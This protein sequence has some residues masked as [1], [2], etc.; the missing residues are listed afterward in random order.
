MVWNDGSMDAGASNIR[1]DR[2]YR[3][4]NRRVAMESMLTLLTVQFFCPVNH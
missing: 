4:H 2:V 1:S 3:I